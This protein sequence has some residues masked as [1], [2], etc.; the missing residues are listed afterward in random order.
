MK[1]VGKP[2]HVRPLFGNA[3]KNYRC[4]EVYVNDTRS[5]RVGQTVFFKHKYLTQ[6]RVTESD[7]LLRSA[8]ELRATLKKSVTPVKG[9]TCQAIDVLIDIFKG[10]AKNTKSP[11]DNQSSEMGKAA[12]QRKTTEVNDPEGERIRSEDIFGD[13]DIRTS[14][15]INVK[16]GNL[17]TQAKTQNKPNVI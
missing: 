1:N 2:H 11:I 4:H 12:K 17:R 7:A 13:D 16:H 5:V 15:Q 3:W 14:P 9:D 6:P 10:V 8:D